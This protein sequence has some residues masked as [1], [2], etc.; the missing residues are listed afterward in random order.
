MFVNDAPINEGPVDKR[1][2]FKLFSLPW[3]DWFREIRDIL[4]G[5][6]FYG[7][8]QT[9]GASISGTPADLTILTEVKKG[10]AYTHEDDSAEVTINTSG[11]YE[12]TLES[13]FNFTQV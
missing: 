1:S 4:A 9:G 10:N 11:T 3:S 8:N 12:I 7:Y 6:C 5:N 2:P 13:G